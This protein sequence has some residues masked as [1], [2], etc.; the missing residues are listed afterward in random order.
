[1]IG[2]KIL[3]K[4]EVNLDQVSFLILLVKLTIVHKKRLKTKARA[5]C[6]DLSL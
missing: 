5:S 2:Y 1:M 3:A 4:G 6:E